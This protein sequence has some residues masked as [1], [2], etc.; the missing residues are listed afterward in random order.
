MYV[1]VSLECPGGLKE[2]VGWIAVKLRGAV[3]FGDLLAGVRMPVFNFLKSGLSF[4]LP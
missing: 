3:K 2:C 4:V 1:F